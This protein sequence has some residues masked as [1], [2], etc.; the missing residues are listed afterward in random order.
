MSYRIAMVGACPYPVPQ[1]SQVL[2][3]DTT[4]CMQSRGH[5][6]WLIVYGFGEGEDASGLS[7]ERCGRLP[8][9]T[10]TMAGPSL[11]KPLLDAMLVF[12]LRRVIRERKIDLV[13][14]H[15]MEGLLV[16]LS[17]GKCPV[18]YHA[19]NA[20]SDELPYFLPYSAP[21]GRLLDRTFPRLANRIIAPHE[22]LAT[23]F[24]E[25][26]GCKPGQVC[27][28]PPAIQNIETN[29]SLDYQASLPP[30][31]YTGNLD[32]YQN[33][34]LLVAAMERVRQT[35]PEARLQVATT[36]RG[37]VAGAEMVYTPNLHSLNTTLK[38][39]CVI[40]CPRVSWSGYPIKLLNTMAMGRPM[41][42]CRSAAHGLI[43]NHDALVVPDNDVAAFADALIE[44]L[45]DVEKRKRL[46]SNAR[47]TL[48]ARHDAAVVAEAIEQC[49]IQAFR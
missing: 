20:M 10:H 3:R 26:C 45:G 13:H 9:K 36:Q 1:G 41:V 22:R 7:I 24:V 38:Q 30:I 19:H 23:Y 42:V 16:G 47:E 21:F 25:E 33:L 14:A 32:T 15:N 4:L 48:R 34:P 12:T 27:V 11:A 46:G 40:A 31:L 44:L 2:L 43:H 49:Y 35:L 37:P 18:I 29:G 17:A 5:E 39:D 28:I 6:M 8:W